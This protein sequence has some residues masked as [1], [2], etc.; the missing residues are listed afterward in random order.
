MEDPGQKLRTVRNRLKLTLRDVLEASQ[1]IRERKGSPEYVLHPGRLFEIETHNVVPSIYR[2][3]SL[4]A[5]Y[6]LDYIQALGWYGVNLADLPGDSLAVNLK[7]THPEGIEPRGSADVMA[8]LSLD[9]GI[10]VRKTNFLS[11]LVSKWGKVPIAML[12]ALEPKKY[13]YAMIGADDWTMYPLLRPGALVL[14]D[15]TKRK[16]ANTGWTNEFERPIYFLETRDGY[17]CA[18]CTLHDSQLMVQPHPASKGTPQV[19][20]FPQE[21][22]VVG[23]VIGVAMLLDPDQGRGIGS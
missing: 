6:K 20:K 9:P 14:I 17:I 7:A 22:E 11:R 13:R 2:L 10:D 15:D 4:C 19:F 1:I 18:W 12:S 8:P 21:I 3:Y 23:Q 16:I 5:I